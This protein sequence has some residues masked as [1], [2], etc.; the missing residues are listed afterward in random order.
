MSASMEA[1]VA[2]APE[3]DRGTKKVSNREGESV[4]PIEAVASA[5]DEVAVEETAMDLE[6]EGGAV[7]RPAVNEGTTDV[8]A[9]VRPSFYDIV[10]EQWNVSEQTSPMPDEEP[11]VECH[12]GDISY[13]PRKYSLAGSGVSH[14]LWAATDNVET[15]QVDEA[16]GCLFCWSGFASSD[17][18]KVVANTNEA[19]RGKYARVAV[20]VDLTKPFQGTVE[21]DDRDFK[22][23]HEGLP[24]VCYGCG[25][26][27]AAKA[28]K[29]EE[30]VLV[31]NKGK[32]V[33]ST[34]PHRS[35]M[36]KRAHG[37]TVG[38]LWPQVHTEEA[39]EPILAPMDVTAREESDADLQLGPLV[40]V[41]QASSTT[42]VTTLGPSVTPQHNLS[43]RYTLSTLHPR[44]RPS[45]PHT[46]PP[47]LNLVGRTK[48]PDKEKKKAPVVLPPKKPALKVSASRK[49]SLGIGGSKPGF[50]GK[51]G[52]GVGIFAFLT[53]GASSLAF[54][55]PTGLWDWTPFQLL[56]PPSFCL[57]ITGVECPK[58]SPGLD[59]VYWRHLASG[60]F[61]TESAYVVAT[62]AD[63]VTPPLA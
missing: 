30:V 56:L 1:S 50:G 24:T 49:L 20:E 10:T 55:T 63:I 29:S 5:A 61:A 46:R 38:I 4:A 2:A 15:V 13:M 23:S 54:V 36:G 35:R 32:S 58:V 52:V 41:G 62:G 7:N 40:M 39:M 57:K 28:Q 27:Q 26:F 22:F 14:S 9:V 60:Q 43:S 6:A 59:V 47:D 53:T 12:D 3:D 33:D 19:F 21:F 37:V 17:M 18:G 34:S 25:T 16:M 8:W 44:A 45:S 42:P 51:I 48:T 11:E 31:A